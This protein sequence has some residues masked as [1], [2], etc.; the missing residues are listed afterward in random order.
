VSVLSRVAL[1]VACWA[2]WSATALAADFYGWQGVRVIAQE[3]QPDRLSSADLDADGRDELILVNTRQSRLDLYAWLPKDR[4]NPPLPV[5][6]ERPNELPLAPEWG[7]YELPLEDLPADALAVDLDGDKRPELLV[8]TGPTLK[9]TVYQAESLGKWKKLR[10]WDLQPG[11]LTGR[12]RLLLLRTRAEP[13][14]QPA[15]AADHPLRR[16]VLVSCEQGIQVIP[17]E[18]EGRATWMHPR[19]TVPRVDWRLLD[20]DGD[21]DRDLV[22]WTTKANQTVRWYECVGGTLRPAQALQDQTAQQVAFLELGAQPAEVLCLGGSQSGL[23]RRYRLARGE[24]SPWGRRATLPLVFG[25]GSPWC[26]VRLG[27][28]V[29]LAAMAVDEPKIRTYRLVDDEWTMEESFPTIGGVREMVAPAASEGTLLL[30]VK[31]AADLYECRWQAG[32]LSFPKPR[33][34]GVAGASEDRRITALDTVGD[35]VWWAQRVGEDL[36]LCVWSPG[37]GEPKRT[38]F[39]KAGSKIERV[40]WL[41]GERL[42]VQQAYSNTARLAIRDKDGKTTIT[43]PPHLSRTTLGEYRLYRDGDALRV[44]R[45]TSGVLQWL[46]DSLHPTDQVM[47]ADGQR[48]ASYVPTAPREALA[49]EEGGAFLHQL[50]FDDAGIARAVKSVKIPPSLALRRDRLAGLLLV[51]SDRVVRLAEGRP[52]ELKLLDTIDGRQG[53]PSGVKEIT[54]HRLLATDVDG[55]GADDLTLCDDRRHQLSVMERRAGELRPMVAW[56]VFEDQAYPYG[57]ESA[58]APVSEPR[59]VL[60]FNADGDSHRDL[61]LLSQ[62]RLLIYLGRETKP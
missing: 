14:A 2:A 8:L 19:E 35:D 20:L 22:E 41:G 54:V 16:E 38:R 37:K 28:E 56:Q 13:A 17:L 31:D 43:D 55:D 12:G 7:H 3:G 30:W 6:P 9:L 45:L 49:V 34:P 1:G 24:S 18:S 32:R 59:A 58:E 61:A 25:P 36:D 46:D 42:L 5:D 47:L 48:M 27:D 57:A 26:G 52:W 44:G 10:H 29:A 21:G 51:D 23:A 33:P 39:E 4:R 53:R 60:G 15:A 62:N 50:K 11:Q 40:Q